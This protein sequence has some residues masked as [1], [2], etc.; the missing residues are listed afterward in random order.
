MQLRIL[1]P[2]EVV[3][4]GEVVAPRAGR[5]RSLLAFL[6][7]HPNERIGADRLIDA[8]WGERPPATA[9]AALQNQVTRLRR[10]LGPERI[11]TAGSTYLLHLAPGEL[12]VD[13]F[14][15]LVR[16]AATAAA[17]ERAELLRSAL[18]LWRGRPLGD[19]EELFAQPEIARLE[20]L[21]LVAVEQRLDA[22][23]ELGESA[24]LVPELEALA[25]EHPLREGIRAKLMLALYRSGRQAEA[26]E[27][28]HQARGLLVDELGIEPQ[29]ALQQLHRR[30]L[31]QDAEL[32]LAPAEAEPAPAVPASAGADAEPLAPVPPR[33]MRKSV[34][35]A[36]LSVELPGEG[37]PELLRGLSER[38]GVVVRHAVERHGGRVQE[39]AG[40]GVLAVFGV[41]VLH[42]DDAIRAVRAADEARHALTDLRAGLRLRAGIATGV[43]IAA[44]DAAGQ[45]V[46]TARELER[47]AGPAEILLAPATQLPRS[48]RGLLR[49]GGRGRATAGATRA[50]GA[51][52]CA[53]ARRAAR[54]PRTRAAAA[55]DRA[56]HTPF[57]RRPV[58]CSRSAVRQ[59]SGNHGWLRSL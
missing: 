22:E 11:E 43:V 56:S 44:A 59:G 36:L 31:L 2:L 8:I 51:G 3:T 34:T 20:E 7:L 5:E 28:Y 12:D 16:R 6:A 4:D 33:E 21:R 15:E 40:A 35:A 23:L 54:R 1:G 14:E 29:Q 24:A 52:C 27:T 42:E 30:I 37:D 17:A 50:G 25:R 55:R 13:R 47:R 41:P 19:V 9:A 18:A 46:E 57:A 53:S 26:L 58:S 39:Q 45:P 10:L 49:A 32:E 48:R 38:A